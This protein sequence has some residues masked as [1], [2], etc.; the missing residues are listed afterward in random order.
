M[1]LKLLQSA[2]AEMKAN[3]EQAV[4][5]AQFGK[6]T[7]LNGQVA[8]EALIRSQRLILG[9]HEAVKKSVSEELAAIGR[10][11]TIYPPV[12]KTTPELSVSGFIKAKK[13][14]VVALVDGAAPISE[15]IMEGPLQG[16]IDRVGLMISGRAIVVGVRSQMSSVAKNFDTLMERAFAEALNLRLRLPSLVMGE[17]YVL[18]VVEY[19]D[20]AM[21]RNKVAWKTKS[22]SVAKFIRTFTGISGRPAGGQTEALY[23]YERSALVLVDFRPKQPRVFLTGAELLKDGLVTDTA[24]AAAFDQLSPQGFAADLIQSHLVRHPPDPVISPPAT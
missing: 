13:Q 8:K 24:T 16:E 12:G 20:V 17:V 3:L 15:I 11:H 19:D 23:K 22:V 7:Y 21:R 1:N 18:P 14:D 6:R 10:Q 2:L 9:V 4:I 5:R